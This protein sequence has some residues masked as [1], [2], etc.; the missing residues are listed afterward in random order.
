[1]RTPSR[2]VISLQQL[3]ED[4]PSVETILREDGKV[5]VINE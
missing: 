1:M 3:Q 2:G 5:T 4:F